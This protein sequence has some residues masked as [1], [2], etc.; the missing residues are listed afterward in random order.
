MDKYFEI[1]NIIDFELLE[2][3]KAIEKI[4]FKNKN[5]LSETFLKYILSGSK[6]IRS[7]ITI[8]LL[9][10]CDENISDNV[11]SI[12]ALIELIHNASLIHDDII[13]N[14]DIRRNLPSFNQQFGNKT[15]VIAGDFLLSLIFD[16][17]CEINNQKITKIFSQTVKNLCMGEIS[18]IENKNKII[19]LD[20][21]LQKTEQKTA[22][23][24]QCAVKSA[25][26]TQ[27]QTQKLE[28]AENFAK[29]FGLAFQIKDDLKNFTKTTQDKPSKNDFLSGILTAP[30]IFYSQQHSI[31]QINTKTFEKI[32]NSFAIRQTE[33]LYS[34][35]SAKAIDL[36]EYFSDNQYKQALIGLC[37]QFMAQ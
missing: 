37:R 24:F 22:T 32:K 35:F 10:A 33:K 4:I 11:I 3:D 17:L 15:A 27:K 20:D 9:K 36:L 30:A 2:I 25:F 34:S 18:Q 8:L 12:C 16:T 7:A 28:F 21:Y 13:D 23:L 29:N 14:S 19:S 1:I 5:F 26:L 6:K 31:D